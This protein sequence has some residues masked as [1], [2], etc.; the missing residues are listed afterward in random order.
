MYRT[1]PSGLNATPGLPSCSRMR[2]RRSR[3]A[4]EVPDEG[5]RRGRPGGAPAAL[6]P[7]HGGR[8]VLP[9]AAVGEVEHLPAPPSRSAGLHRQRLEG[10]GI[11]QH[12]PGCRVGAAI[13]TASV[14]PSGLNRTCRDSHSSRASAPAW[15]SPQQLSGA[16]L[17]EPHVVRLV[18]GGDGAAVGAHVE[19]DDAGARHLR[20]RDQLGMSSQ[21]GEQAAP[22]LR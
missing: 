9:V 14:C 22:G 1:L 7:P 10:L 11:E 16:D 17:V 12:R 2:G 5:P 8:Q 13:T 20:R 21:R 6:D 18:V 4:C 15:N 19:V 3:G